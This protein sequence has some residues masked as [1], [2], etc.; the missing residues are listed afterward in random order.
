[1]KKPLITLSLFAL[2]CTP[3]M[4]AK[5]VSVVSGSPVTMTTTSTAP[6]ATTVVSQHANGQI[7]TVTTTPTGFSMVNGMPFYPTQ[8]TVTPTYRTVAPVATVAPVTTVTPAPVASVVPVVQTGPST[9]VTTK[10]QTTQPVM[11]TNPVT[12]VSKTVNQ[13]A[14]IISSTTTTPIATPVSVVTPVVT[15]PT[16]VINP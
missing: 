1:M 15:T 10:T 2:V 7:S 8:I 6:N 16:V 12:G 11:V 14:T 13:P 9:T 4:A 5:S 3:A